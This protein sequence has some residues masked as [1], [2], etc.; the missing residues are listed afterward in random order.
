MNLNASTDDTSPWVATRCVKLG[1]PFGPQFFGP[2][3]NRFQLLKLLCVV[4]AINCRGIV[5]DLVDRY[6]I[7]LLVPKVNDT[8]AISVRSETSI[9]NRSMDSVQIGAWVT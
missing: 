4:N 1:N 3:D 9:L 7:P 6:E 8:S 5:R 2:L